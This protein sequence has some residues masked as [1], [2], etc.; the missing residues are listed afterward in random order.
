MAAEEA[1]E[2]EAKK[3]EDDSGG[4]TVT[5]TSK[6]AALVNAARTQQRVSPQPPPPQF[7]GYGPYSPLPNVPSYD[8][9]ASPYGSQP[10]YYPQPPPPQ[11]QQFPGGYGGYPLYASSAQQRTPPQLQ[12]LS[13]SV[14]AWL[15]EESSG[16]EAAGRRSSGGDERE[17]TKASSGKKR[18]PSSSGGTMRRESPRAMEVPPVLL[19]VRAAAGI[20]AGTAG[21]VRV[22]LDTVARRRRRRRRRPAEA[23]HHA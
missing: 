19:W 23:G 15:E 16:E 11:Q 20:P 7:A 5:P 12:P 18:P 1:A 3:A 6:F 10:G 8:Q 14:D 4:D 22:P 17:A 21:V 2:A 13:P 9:Y